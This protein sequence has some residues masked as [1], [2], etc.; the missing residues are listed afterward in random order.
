MKK[1]L[2]I[3]NWKA[4]PDSPGRAVSLARSIE[5]GIARY[6]N[7]EVVIAPPYPFLLPVARVLR[8]S[9]LGAQDTSWHDTGPFTGEVSWHHLKHMG[10]KYVIVGHSERKIYFGESDS[11]INKKVQVLL[12][13]GLIPI[14]CI[15][16]RERGGGEIPI[17]V[18]EQLKKALA[19]VR[20]N[21]IKNL[22]VA[23]EP[24]WAISTM[25]DARPD[26]PDNAFRAMV[27]IR[28][29]ISNLYDRKTADLVRVIYG[30]S[31]KSK[32]ISLFLKEGRMEGALVGG[33]SLKAQEFA[34]IVAEA[35]II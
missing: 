27:Y 19:G 23:Y 26:T 25:P 13:H 16:E 3:A 2:I 31:V 35:S 7:V 12:Q 11:M 28:R 5:C 34:E 24:I 9:K 32:N 29:V 14:L 33:A 15:G 30:G 4:N 22:V 10:V 6:R 8:K 1:P 20:R 18:G 21:F 17:M